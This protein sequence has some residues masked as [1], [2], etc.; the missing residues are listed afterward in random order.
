M[1]DGCGHVA[2]ATPV[3]RHLWQPPFYQRTHALSGNAGT[4]SLAGF[5][6]GSSRSSGGASFL[7]GRVAEVLVYPR[8]LSPSEKTA[9]TA[10]AQAKH[11]I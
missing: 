2:T 4:N 11:G 6:L 3:E 9:I 5:T 7:N 10:Y 8:K 1:A